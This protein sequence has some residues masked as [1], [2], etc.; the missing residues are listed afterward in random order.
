MDDG[1]PGPWFAARY[2]GRC[3]NC[4]EP[5]DEGDRIRADG[6]GGY[7]CCEPDPPPAPTRFEGTTDEQMG[8]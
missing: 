6:D 8:F 7:E 2:A 1:A 4:H 3:P 5:Y